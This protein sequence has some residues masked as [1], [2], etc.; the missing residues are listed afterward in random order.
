MLETALWKEFVLQ[1]FVPVISKT[2]FNITTEKSENLLFSSKTNVLDK[3]SA[4]FETFSTNL[5]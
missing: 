1:N 2:I 4:G 5:D 3:S